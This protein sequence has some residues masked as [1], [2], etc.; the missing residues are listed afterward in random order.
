[1]SGVRSSVERGRG[2]EGESV[3]VLVFSRFFSRY[4][5]VSRDALDIWFLTVL[6]FSTGNAAFKRGARL[7]VVSADARRIGAARGVAASEE[8]SSRCFARRRAS[9][10]R[11]DLLRF[12]VFATEK[13]REKRGGERQD[14]AENGGLQEKEREVRAQRDER[15][16]RQREKKQRGTGTEE[17]E[18]KESETGRQRGA[19]AE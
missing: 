19:A 14:D 15:R 13:F 1:M 3:G 12:R 5:N 4:L 6:I 8:P 9:D 17:G 2:K 10:A 18:I 11:D 7:T 16:R